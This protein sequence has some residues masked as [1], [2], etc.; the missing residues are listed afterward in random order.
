MT[1]REITVKA[2][3]EAVLL[4]EATRH[5]YGDLCRVAASDAA[6]QLRRRIVDLSAQEVW[7]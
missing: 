4:I 5:D 3:R 1:E 2:W 6:R 7:L